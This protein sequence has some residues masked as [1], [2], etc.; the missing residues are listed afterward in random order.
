MTCEALEAQS[1]RLCA[2]NM[3][4]EEKK[5]L[6]K[7]A[8]HL[9]QL[10]Q[11]GQSES[12]ASFLYSVH[13]YHMDVHMR[14]AEFARCTGLSKAIEKERGLV[15]NWLYG[16][17]ARR[18]V[19]QPNSHAKLAAAICSGDTQKADEVMSAHIRRS[20]DKVSEHFAKLEHGNALRSCGASS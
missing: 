3:T 14:I 13:T 12:D 10:Y 8:E 9:D 11:A 1:A 6:R 4:A 15:F 20:F 5:Q 2:A 18:A 17:S 7:S 16:T 19:S